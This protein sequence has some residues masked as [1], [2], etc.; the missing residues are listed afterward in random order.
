MILA[1]LASMRLAW[2]F[3][4]RVLLMQLKRGLRKN[5]FFH[6]ISAAIKLT[7]ICFSV[8]WY[9]SYK[10]VFSSLTLMPQKSGTFFRLV[11][12]LKHSW[13]YQIR[14]GK[15]SQRHFSIDVNLWQNFYQKLSYSLMPKVNLIIFFYFLLIENI[16]HLNKKVGTLPRK[17]DLSLV[18]ITKFYIEAN[19]IFI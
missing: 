4:P 9:Q 18:S 3:L 19:I 16:R 14:F 8:S 15:T 6:N 12:A 7:K 11:N 13:K 2:N 17:N 10:T 1:L 5:K